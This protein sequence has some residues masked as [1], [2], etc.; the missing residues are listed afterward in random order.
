MST[1]AIRQ[2]ILSYHEVADVKK[3]KAIYIMMETEIEEASVAYTDEFRKELKQ[4]YEAYK[5]NPSTAVTT[6]ES[7]RRIQKILKSARGY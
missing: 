5:Q 3:I 7:K 6:A 2:K 4:R 1:V